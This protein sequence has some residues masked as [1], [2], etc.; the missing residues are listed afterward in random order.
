MNITCPRKPLSGKNYL[1]RYNQ[2]GTLLR[3]SISYSS[4]A[5]PGSS[6]NPYLLVG[7]SIRKKDSIF[8]K[9]LIH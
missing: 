3:K 9:H 2:D 7:D 8:G 6:K 4:S 5:T 1:I